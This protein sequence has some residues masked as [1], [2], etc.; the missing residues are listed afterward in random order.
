MVMTIK[1]TEKPGKEVWFFL[2]IV[3]KGMW[4]FKENN[5]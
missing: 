2:I 5:T 1:E 3:P 4:R